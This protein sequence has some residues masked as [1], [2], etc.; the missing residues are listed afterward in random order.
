M[1]RCW[2]INRQTN[3]G[4][5]P[6][7]STHFYV[8]SLV[9]PSLEMAPHTAS[10]L[11]GTTAPDA[12]DPQS[13]QSF[14]RYHFKRSDGR[15][16]LQDFVEVTNFTNRPFDDPAWCFTCGYYCH[17]W[18]DAFYMDNAQHLHFKR[19]PG[20]PDADWRSLIRKESEILNAP[21][22]LKAGS[23]PQ[24]D[25]LLLPAGLEF[26]NFERCIDLFHE[27]LR[28]S[29]TWSVLADELVSLDPGEY[30]AFLGEASKIF[31]DEFQAA[32]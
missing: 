12:F 24:S 9:L 11:L 28:Q 25:N 6:P 27:V 4:S 2:L 15:I 19:P 18:L 26:V 10:F 5:M 14:S 13:E 32:A 31:L 1:R 30:A 23:L 20:M 22:V 7:L 3:G 21:F 17:L 8:A 29:Q 16:G